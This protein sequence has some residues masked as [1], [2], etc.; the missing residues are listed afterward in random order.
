MASIQKRGSKYQLRVSRKILPRPFFFTF[1]TEDEAKAYGSQLEALLDRGIVPQELLERPAQSKDILFVEVLRGWQHSSI[2]DSDHDMLGTVMGE[3][4]GVRLSAVTYQ[5]VE[6][7]VRQCKFKR[8]LAPGTIRKRI[9][10]FGR[11][12]D[13]HSRT[14]TLKDANLPANP[15]R[16]LPVGYSHYS[17]QDA[18]KVEPKQDIE[19]DRRLHDGEHEQILQAL[20]GVRR[21][22]RER[23]LTQDA[24]LIML[25]LLL[26]DTGLRLF[27]AYRLRVDSIDLKAN[28]IKVEGSKGARGKNKPRTVPIKPALREVLRDYCHGRIGLL[29]PYWSGDKADK[30]RCSNTLSNRFRSVFDYAGVS[31]LSVHD[32]R[33]EATCRW[34]EL[35][36]PTGGWVFSEVEVAKIMGWSSL[37]MM[38]RYAS[39]RGSDLAA[40]MG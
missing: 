25:Y 4:L 16:L 32:L 1:D 13:W 26:L 7:Y 40:R 39:I 9:G 15:F 3:V 38:L 11:A 22:D 18:L 34:L 35:R 31:D 5:W 6:E 23:P 17:D 21:P 12:L 19:R 30:V 24:A 14:V 27:E 29:F 37:K 28:T 8:N 10:L 20:Q 36:T 2:S 33:H